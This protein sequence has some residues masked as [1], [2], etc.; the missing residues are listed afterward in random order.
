M[1]L[2]VLADRHMRGA[3][4]QNVGG[5]QVG[6][7]IEAD[8]GVLA[9]LAGLLLELRHAV[10]P[11]ERATQLNTQASSACSGT[12]LWLKTMC[13]FGSMPQ[14]MKAA[15]TSRVARVS[16]AGSCQTVIACRSTTQ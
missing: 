15:V 12:W 4:D 7:G 1:L 10:E 11:A 13:F 9:V 6:I 5:H 16:S 14:A 8:G 2:L 3:I